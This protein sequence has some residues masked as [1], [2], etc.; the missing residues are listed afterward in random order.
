MMNH[1]FFKW[2]FRFLEM[3]RQVSLWSKDPSTKI[4]AIAVGLDGQIL[5]Q[6]YNGFPRGVEDLASRLNNREVKYDFVVHAEMNCIFNACLSGITLKDSTLY[7]FGLPI[8]HRCTPGIIQV[9][10][11]KV[12]MA[13]DGENTKWMDS[14]KLSQTMLDEAG[15]DYIGF[16]YTGKHWDVTAGLDQSCQSKHALGFGHNPVSRAKSFS[17]TK[18]HKPNI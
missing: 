13:Y 14:W 4:G 12:V 5:T 8:C 2:D 7:V 15:I 11:K 9:G 10:V 18:Q 3:A 6:G 17:E 1:E 16:K